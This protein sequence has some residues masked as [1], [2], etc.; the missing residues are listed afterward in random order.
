[1]KNKVASKDFK[2]SD[3]PSNR[4]EVFFDCFKNRYKYLMYCGFII[5]F[6][7]IPFLIICFL[8]SFYLSALVKELE[9]SNIT[10]QDYN[11]ASLRYALIYNGFIVVSSLLISIGIS[12]ATRVI[13]Q[14]GWE[15]PVFFTR[16][17]IDGI[18]MNYKQIFV[19]V[20]L[21]S[22]IYMISDLF[23]YINIPY[24]IFRYIPLVIFIFIVFPIS[25]YS[26][27]QNNIYNMSNIKVTTNSL[28]FFF[29]SV[30]VCILFSLTISLSLLIGFIP[31]FTIR[32]LIYVLLII[33]AFPLYYLAWF[34]HSSSMFDKYLNINYYPELMD[35]GITRRR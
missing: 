24:M 13:R 17:F 18:K 30:P 2:I 1:M 29:K 9:A 12:G 5:L 22:L 33:F 28:L 31:N 11:L 20:F 3:L 4:K 6:C 19:H 7:A 27:A 14:I 23:L 16:D 21:L 15:E 35:K 10:E 25:L 8:K 34:L 26:V 32:L